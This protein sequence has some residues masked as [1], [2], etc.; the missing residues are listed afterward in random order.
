MRQEG[1]DV[2][3][4]SGVCAKAPKAQ[5]CFKTFVHD[6]RSYRKRLRIVLFQPRSLALE[7]KL[8]LFRLVRR[9]K[10][11]EKKMAAQNV[12]ERRTVFPCGLFAVSLNGLSDIGT[13]RSLVL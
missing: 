10:K 7:T 9:K 1:E 3:V 4:T 13:T 5:L 2:L 8:S 11:R 12:R 6:C